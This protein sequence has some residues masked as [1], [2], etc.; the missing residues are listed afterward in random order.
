MN[1]R[2]A[3]EIAFVGLKPGVHEFDYKIDDKFFAEYGEQDFTN[4]SADVKLQLERH[5]GF[6]ML[7][8][9][10]GGKSDVTCD[11]CGNNLTMNLWDEFKIM[12]KMVDEPEVMNEQEEDPDVYYISKTESHLFVGD[13]IYEFINLSLPLQK[14]CSEEEVGGPQC[15]KEVLEQLKRMAEGSKNEENP[16][17]KDLDQFKNLQ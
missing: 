12:V 3:Y 10:I 6:L 13:W 9:D 7:K 14:R 5:S 1:N 4:V 16:I 15:N 17:W 8:F 2:R 11:R